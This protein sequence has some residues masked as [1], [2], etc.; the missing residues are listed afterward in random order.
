MQKLR[1]IIG[2]LFIFGV[3]FSQVLNEVIANGCGS[4]A[5]EFLLMIFNSL[6]QAAG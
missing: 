2:F 4:N 6:Y 3:A 5:Q 1:A